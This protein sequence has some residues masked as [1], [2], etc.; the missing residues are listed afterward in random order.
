MIRI[1]RSFVGGFLMGTADL[2][3]GVSGGTI[4]LVLGIYERLVG[5]IR[6]GSSALGSLFRGD[7]T[8]FKEHLRKV[9]WAFLLPLLA[10]ILAA[11][12]AL[13]S[14]LDQQL[15]EQPT[16]LAG[17]FFGLVVGSVIIAWRLLRQ[18]MPSH[19]LVAGV[20]GVVLFVVLGLGE[21]AVVASPGLV[22][23]FGAGAIAICAMILPGI[24]G[25]LILLL[26]GMYPSVL[27]AVDERDLLVVGVFALGT[28]VGLG[29][30][31][32]VLHW[33][34][35]RHHDVILAGLVGLMA[36]SLRVLWPW[37]EGVESSGLNA[38]GDDWLAALVA[39]VVGFG[40]VFVV[41]R[42]AEPKDDE[43]SEPQLAG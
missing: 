18:P 32:Q 8:V 19:Y 17:L 9:E 42:L 33:A 10:G 12:V 26:I 37:P 27:N 21:E 28:I 43:I 34:L 15:E 25:S 30:F 22:V 40:V 36:G 14:L 29:F 2:V 3:P 13:A 31:S 24:S 11:V 20:V 35:R 5:S 39:S 1:I 6:E 16:L 41:F 4:A 23:F 38:P 7:F